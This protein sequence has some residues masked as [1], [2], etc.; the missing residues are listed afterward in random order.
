MQ[1]AKIK[2]KVRKNQWKG[3]MKEMEEKT[4][5]DSGGWSRHLVGE[6]HQDKC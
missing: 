4:Y 6:N 3:N 1:I 2:K 5:G